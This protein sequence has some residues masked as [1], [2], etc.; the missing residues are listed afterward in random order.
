[1]AWDTLMEAFK[2]V[3]KNRERLNESDLHQLKG[4]L[5]STER[6]SG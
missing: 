5:I 4:E 2:Y 1:M 3:E 6:C